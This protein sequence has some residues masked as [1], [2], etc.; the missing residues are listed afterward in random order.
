MTSKTLPAFPLSAVAADGNT[1]DLPNDG[2]T[3]ASVSVNIS[4]IAGTTPTITFTV[5]GKD[6]ASGTYYTLLAST[7][8]NATG[9]VRLLVGPGLT[10]AANAAANAYLPPVFRVK[11]VVGGTLPV[12]TGTIGVALVG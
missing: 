3:A 1:G 7:A 9:L 10:A 11:W 12:V 2:N 6:P 8:L 4:A 5:E